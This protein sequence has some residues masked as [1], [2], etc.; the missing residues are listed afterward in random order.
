MNAVIII[1]GIIFLIIIIIFLSLISY[2]M[3]KL[4]NINN[5]QQNIIKIIQDNTNKR[6]SNSIFMINAKNIFFR[7]NNYL[8][9]DIMK[10]ICMSAD[11]GN[12][13][14][15]FYFKECNDDSTD[16]PRMVDDKELKKYDENIKDIWKIVITTIKKIETPFYHKYTDSEIDNM[17]KEKLSLNKVI[18]GENL[19]IHTS[20]Q[21][22]LLI[23]A[24]VK[25]VGIYMDIISNM[26]NHIID[27][28]EL[29]TAL[30][31]KFKY[32]IEGIIIGFLTQ[33]FDDIKLMLR[34]DATKEGNADILLTIFN[35]IGDKFNEIN[36]E[37]Q[38]SESVNR[39]Y[40][41]PKF[42]NNLN[43][44]ED[45]IENTKQQFE[46]INQDHFKTTLNYK[47]P[48]KYNNNQITYKG[49]TGLEVDG[50]DVHAF[51]LYESAKPD[52]WKTSE[53]LPDFKDIFI[54]ESFLDERAKMIIKDEKYL[55]TTNE[56][57][58]KANQKFL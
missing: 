51:R 4:S 25:I 44:L 9:N 35:E 20:Y 53:T 3:Y 46:R 7:F 1:L 10:K 26:I 5:E 45:K 23:N 18:Q 38:F 55:I 22:S 50:E 36:I 17:I 30:F 34:R 8:I 33:N 29:K 39:Y 21:A 40:E 6:F 42:R 15:P 41:T 31:N 13:D 58:A 54:K 49:L 52:N 19:K 2:N 47:I 43:D 28:I 14:N 27:D 57:F 32:L 56:L 12:H 24:S 16:N 37:D 11:I 48:Q